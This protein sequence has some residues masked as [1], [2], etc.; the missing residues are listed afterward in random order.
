MF[1]V[2]AGVL[3]P[4]GSFPNAGQQ[5]MTHIP[6]LVPAAFFLVSPRS[7]LTA[8]AQ[9]IED[10]DIQMRN[11]AAR[12]IQ[13]WARRRRHRL[14]KRKSTLFDIVA[15]HSRVKFGKEVHLMGKRVQRCEYLCSGL[16]G[17]YC[18]GV[19]TVIFGV[20]FWVYVLSKAGAQRARCEYEFGQMAHC[21]GCRENL[22]LHLVSHSQ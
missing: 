14:Q 13:Q 19:I 4:D 5:I 17:I 18:A 10:A 1:Q 20:A 2:R 21:V 7:S 6:T 16:A 8:L 12:K 11:A 9:L 15:A 3:N 22:I